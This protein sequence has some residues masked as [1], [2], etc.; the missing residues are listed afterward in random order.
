MRIAQIAPLAEPVPPERYGGTE[1]VIGHLVDELVRHGHEVTLFA[2]GDSTAPA[3][4]LIAPT[5]Q[6]L[7]TDP[8][9][10]DKLAPHIQ[11]LGQVIE[12]AESFD[13]I[14]SHVD[15]VAFPTAALF[16][17]PTV[18]TLHGRLDLP[19][20]RPVF[21]QFHRLA[22][23]SISDAQRVPLAGL[24]INWVGTVYHGLPLDE[25]PF[26]PNGGDEL[27]YLARMSREKRP[28]L[29]IEIAKRVGMKLTMAAKVD[30][31]DKEYFER[32][33]RP[34][35]DHPLIDFV[36]E[37]DH[38]RKVELLSRARALLFPIDWPEPFGLAMIEAMAC[39]TPVVTRP[40]GA[41]PEIIAHGR[42]GLVGS[43]IDE[44]V[45]AVKGVDRLDRRE[46]RRE[47]EERFNASRMA[48][49]YEHVYCQLL[50]T[51]RAAS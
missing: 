10:K 46:C 47:V 8:T 12:R 37:V 17:T 48:T 4:D 44:L 2:S 51:S 16:P 35:L 41:V 39:G 9:V 29:A 40:C 20:L 25:Y 30:A 23:V 21:A 13:V 36:G 42:T 7:R 33:I 43:S 32:D 26:S 15:Y 11:E 22:M 28:D 3:D 49:D 45:D 38:K 19:H 1:R 50:E 34:L 24:G 27:V 18:H 14:H 5:R 6:S 31:T